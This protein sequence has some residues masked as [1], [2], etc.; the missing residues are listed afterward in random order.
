MLTAKTRTIVFAFHPQA[1]QSSVHAAK[2]VYDAAVAA[3]APKT[4]FNGSKH[5]QLMQQTH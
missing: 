1:Q 3:G 2:V 5:L 4:S